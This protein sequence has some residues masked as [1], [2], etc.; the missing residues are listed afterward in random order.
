MQGDKGTDGP[1][2][3]GPTKE[4]QRSLLHQQLQ[5]SIIFVLSFVTSSSLNANF[6]FSAPPLAPSNFTI[7]NNNST[8][9]IFKFFITGVE[10]WM[11]IEVDFNISFHF[12]LELLLL[13][14]L[15]LVGVD[16]KAT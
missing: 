6:G 12:I 16:F 4:T 7:L 10:S 1:N 8:F 3:E 14:L 11:G 9:F 13:L 2:L 15:V 5:I